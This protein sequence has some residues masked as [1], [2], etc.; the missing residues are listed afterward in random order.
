MCAWDFV[1]LTNRNNKKK[2]N[3]R[4]AAS[5]SQYYVHVLSKV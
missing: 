3:E 5:P 4:V 1:K 2:K